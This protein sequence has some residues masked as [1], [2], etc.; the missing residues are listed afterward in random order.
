MMVITHDH[1][2]HSYRLACS[3][4]DPRDDYIFSVEWDKEMNEITLLI[5]ANMFTQYSTFHRFWLWEKILNLY[6]RMSLALRILVTGYYET[7]GSITF[8]G[9]DQ[10]ENLMLAL[11]W[12]MEKV[13]ASGREYSEY[14]KNGV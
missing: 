10:I 11:R 5:E 9:P 2:W 13:E 7:S 8:H 6:E 1:I 3:C 12:S 4:Y 14:K